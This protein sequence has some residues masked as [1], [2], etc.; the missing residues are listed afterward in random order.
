MMKARANLFRTLVVVWAVAV[1]VA[2]ALFGVSLRKA[3]AQTT[4][5]KMQVQDLGPLGG[6][7]SYAT[8][9]N[10]SGQVVGYSDAS[11]GY[12]HAF[13][14]DASATPKMEDLDTLGGDFSRALGINNSGKVVGWSYTN[15][16]E[17]HAFIYD[18]TN[19]MQDLNDLIPAN[20]GETIYEASAINSKGQIAATIFRPLLDVGPNVCGQEYYNW[21]IYLAAVLTPAT[22]GTPTTYEVQNL[23]TLGADFSEAASING[24]GQ[25][26]GTSWDSSCWNHAFL[27]D[28]ATQKMLD[29]GALGGNY[30]HAT[31]I[32]DSGQVVGYGDFIGSHAFL[33]DSATQKVQD[34]GD[35]EGGN[36]SL[37]MGINDSGQVVGRSY[38]G[39]GS[40][41]SGGGRAF[42]YDSTNGMQNLNGLI[43]SDSGWTI[44]VASAIDSKGQIAATG[45]KDGV[46]THA[47]LLTPTSSDTRAPSPPI[48][49][50]PQNSTYDT[51]GSFSVSGSAEAGSTVKLF[52]GTTSIDSTKAD[53]SSGAWSIP[54]SGVSVGAHTYTAKATD[55]AGNTSSASNSVTVTVDKTAPTITSVSPARG[56]TKVARNTMVT[57]TFA[58][59]MD[60]KTLITPKDLANP[61]EG[62]STTFTLVKY[63]T[64]TPILGATVSYNDSTNKVMLT[65]STNLDARTKYTAKITGDAKDLAGNALSGAPYTWNFTTGS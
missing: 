10:D 19:G 31:G 23:G 58:E 15:S 40:Y 4:T 54:L 12:T 47:L 61:N 33:Y 35:L 34:L 24:S 28:S 27:Y 53:S 26:A 16:G 11:N 17:Q 50:S 41:V 39:S 46:G 21:G 49:T 43:P 51:D 45:Y 7:R 2:V 60:P 65:P 22:A 32:N 37:A 44:Y 13:L 36:W 38:V 1:A 14:Y 57:A 64:T 20:S 48:I 8:G 3:E 63:G 56:A 5:S 59:K 62:T 29:L 18:S 55:A 25:V 9:I 42:L 52:E 6:S 30:S